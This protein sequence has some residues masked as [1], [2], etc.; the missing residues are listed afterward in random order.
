MLRHFLNR[1]I[2]PHERDDFINEVLGNLLAYDLENQSELVNTLEVWINNR[3]NIAQAAREL[4]IHRN[5]M[6]YRISNI[7]DLLQ[8]DLEEPTEL[9]SI[10]LALS[11]LGIKLLN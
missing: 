6:L 5:T 10:Q 9:L 7:E 11:L 1:N 3:L 4:F 8:V 2:S